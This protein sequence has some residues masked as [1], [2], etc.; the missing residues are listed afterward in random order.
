MSAIDLDAIEARANAASA[1]PWTV[2]VRA[3]CYFHEEIV[4]LGGPEWT[5]AH[6]RN[7]VGMDTGTVEFIAEPDATFIAHART[8]IPALVAR[9]REL[10]ARLVGANVAAD[11]LR[12]FA[13][14]LNLGRVVP[15]EHTPDALFGMALALEGRPALT[16]K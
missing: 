4:G 16:E 15:T 7:A 2:D 6:T 12:C 10:E 9:V 14:A 13:D 3:S 1:G 11:A 8:D 5:R